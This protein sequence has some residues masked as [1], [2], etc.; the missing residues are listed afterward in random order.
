VATMVAAI[1]GKVAQSPEVAFDPVEERGGHVGQ[2]DIVGGRPLATR[3][4]FR[5]EVGLYLSKTMA[6]R[7]W[8]GYNEHR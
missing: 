6:M 2:L 4:S 8:G 1:E 3:W 7:T 5:V